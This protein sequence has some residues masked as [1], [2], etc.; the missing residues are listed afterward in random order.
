[1]LKMLAK[2]KHSSLPVGKAG[3]YPSG[4]PSHTM[5]MLKMIAR[6]ILSS[7][8]AVKVDHKQHHKYSIN[9]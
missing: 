2:D 7:F 9:S 4:A 5:T 8:S 3:T 1:M 6:E